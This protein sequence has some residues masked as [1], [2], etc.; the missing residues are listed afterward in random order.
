MKTFRLFLTLVLTTEAVAATAL[1][2]WDQLCQ[3]ARTP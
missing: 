1:V 3:E 2:T